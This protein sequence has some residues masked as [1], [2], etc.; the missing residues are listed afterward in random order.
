MHRPSLRTKSASGRLALAFS[1]LIFLTLFVVT[2]LPPTSRATQDGNQSDV[3]QK[4]PR[5][6]FVPGEVLVRYRSE[7]VA[8]RQPHTA[9]LSAKG[10]QVGIKIERFDG[11]NIVPGLRIA[12]V[13]AAD[14]MTAIE[15]LKQ[16]PD[17]LYAEPNYLLYLDMT[18]ND[19]RFTSGDLYGL[20]KIGAP[21]A[22]NTTT[23]SSSVVVAVIDEGID[24]LH[25]DLQ[26]NIWTN[27]AEV[28]GNG[29]DDDG[30]GFIDD[31]NGFNF[32]G[33]TGTIPAENHATHV[34]GTIGAVGNNN[35][36]V[37]GV[38]WQVSLMSLRFIDGS[39]GSTADAIR[40]CNYS[41]QMHDLWV[42]TNGAKGANVRVLNNSYG[43]GGFS[44][45]FF[46][47][48]N[49]LNQS[50]IL[51][52]AAAGN[53]P[54]SPEPNNDLVPHYPSGYDAPNV[55]SV[56]ATDSNDALASFSHFGATSVDLGAPGVG[57]LSTT[58]NNTYS[59]F[60]GTSMATPH[61][62]GA[63]ALLL[64]Q[65]PNLT[66]QQL[67]SL[68]IFN[69]DSVS[70]LAGKTLTGRRL[71]VANSFVALA[72]NDTTPPGTVTNFH[73]NSQV[74]R[75]L[76]VGWTSSGD[77]GA[78]GQ[79]SLYK[80]TFTDATT[81]T[82]IFLQ[83]VFPSATGVTQSIDVKLPYRHTNGTLTLREFDNVGNEGVPATFAVSVSPVEGDP[84]LISLG[85]SVALS[86]GG[87][88]LALIGD[89]ELKL[90]YA[91]PFAFPFFGENFSMV[92]VSTNGNLFFSA[93]PT[94][95]NGDA[96]DVPSSSI[97]M[98]K[99]KMISGMWDDLR[100]DKRP[101]DDVYVVTPDANR[102]IFR[103]QGVT[104]GDGTAA[105]EFP[106]NFEIELRSNGTILS[107]YGSGQAAPINTNLFPVVGVSGGEPEAYVISSHTAEQAET[108]LTNAP[109]VTFLPRAVGI[110]SSVQ[111]SVS[112]FNFTETDSSATL[113]VVRNGD[114]T[115]QSSVDYLTSDGAATQKGD[116]TFGSGTINFAAGETSKSVTVLLVDDAF[117]EGPES[118]SVL[119][120]NPVNTALGARNVAAVAIADNDVSPPTTNPLDNPNAIFF[121]RQ[122]YLDFLNREPDP[123]GFAFW[124]NQITSCGS[125]QPC[126]DVKRINVSAAF[127]LSIEFQETGYL[128]YR[129]YKVAFNPPG[130]PVPVRYEEFLSDTQ[131]IGKGIVVN[132]GD[133]QTQLENNKLAFAAEFVLRLRFIQEHPISDTP[134][135]FVDELYANA[136]VTPSPAERTAVINEFG[137]APNSA[138][139]A[140]RAR[141]LRLLAENSTLKQQEFNKAFVLMQYFGYLRRNPF[142]PPEP[143]L[144]FDGYN[145][146][147]NKLNE[148]NGNF[149]NAEMV[150][151]FILSGEYRGRFGP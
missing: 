127:F 8:N 34:A 59:F 73:L 85:S 101:G 133:W 68:L 97:G 92:N 49:A 88:P 7:R 62:A 46:D 60:N 1:F 86:V 107:R 131:E 17:V 147:L 122:H 132:V 126:I 114:T 143:S 93:P 11:S 16:Q 22:W 71:N 128:V 6:E 24:K 3:K 112:Q 94:R 56:A 76:N 82:V 37:V 38:N 12:R 29:I 25:P 42:S 41:R 84:Y 134:A 48:I 66:V 57:I 58:T 99:F 149:V 137:A 55:I 32:A 109:E 150:K 19:P 9:T 69:G 115:T 52:V 121:V 138:D 98:T 4:Q 35:T 53:A 117:Q 100:T 50:G 90:N 67:K 144:N 61:V 136:G 135:Q 103:W 105:T 89:D 119:L 110:T 45:S 15:A 64:A 44:Q 140:A 72:E 142:D 43:G 28:A 118:F 2:A 125:D 148:F 96:D 124:T 111:F 102:I 33:N 80:L 31:V 151:A 54:D 146:W 139:T 26:A 108:N 141:V 123:N 77:D 47:A 87:A 5:P 83:S 40:A 81:G 120:S 27:P 51:F 13:A 129:M 70:S 95:A 63:T 91:L 130:I 116:Y 36:G 145:F 10:R 21:T 65:N 74:G 39:S 18:P 104:F 79:A 20:T 106:F 14:T 78:V 113:T 75:A 23:G 30:N